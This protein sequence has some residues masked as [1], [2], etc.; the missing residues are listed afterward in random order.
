LIHSRQSVKGCL[1]YGVF[2]L[3]WSAFGYYCYNT[4]TTV[5]L[6][7]AAV[8]GFVLAGIKHQANKKR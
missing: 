1:V 3:F 2:C 5:V 8:L 7:I 4:L 6:L